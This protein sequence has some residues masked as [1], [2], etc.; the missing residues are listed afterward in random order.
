MFGILEKQ[1]LGQLA[2]STDNAESQSLALGKSLLFFGEVEPIE[3]IREKIE[4]IDSDTLL[5]VANELF[6]REKMFTLIYS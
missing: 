3:V 1:L 4:E 2:I 6:N 5:E